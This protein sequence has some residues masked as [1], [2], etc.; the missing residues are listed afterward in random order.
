MRNFLN[1]QVVFV[2]GLV[3]SVIFKILN[4]LFGIVVKEK[5]LFQYELEFLQL[6][7][8]VQDILDIFDVLLVERKVN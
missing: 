7:R 1:F 3:E 6:E 5:D 2:C 8:C 4:D